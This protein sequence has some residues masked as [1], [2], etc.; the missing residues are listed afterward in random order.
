LHHS[1][2]APLK[3]VPVPEFF[4][5]CWFLAR[6]TTLPLILPSIPFGMVIALARDRIVLRGATPASTGT[7][8]GS[9]GSNVPR[10]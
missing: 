6:I 5:Q 9:A 7:A 3:G 2:Q 8:S 1:E 4:D 10:Q